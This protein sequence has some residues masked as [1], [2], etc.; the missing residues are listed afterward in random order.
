MNF[1]D[2]YIIKSERGLLDELFDGF[3]FTH[4]IENGQEY[5]IATIGEFVFCASSAILLAKRLCA[6]NLD[7]KS[8]MS[9]AKAHKK[10]SK[11]ISRLARLIKKEH[12]N[13]SQSQLPI[14]K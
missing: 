1:Y 6:L 3:S 2:K 9:R 13:D 4:E 5:F 12:G 14:S 8:I 10:T 7:V 11:E